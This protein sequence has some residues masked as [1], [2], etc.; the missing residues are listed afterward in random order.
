MTQEEVL[1]IVKENPG[2]TTTQIAII[3]NISRP[4]TGTS[5]KKLHN[6]GL[7]IYE[8]KNKPRPVRIWYAPKT[9]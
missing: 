9:I 3:L 4:T 1:Q 2:L 8:L 7:V 5:L 6:Q